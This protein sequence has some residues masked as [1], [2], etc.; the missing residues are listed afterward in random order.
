MVKDQDS[1]E[2]PPPRPPLAVSC[3]IIAKNEEARIAR[4]IRSVTGLVDEVVVVDSGSTDRTIAICRELGAVVHLNDWAGY[5]PQKRFAELQCRN[6]W[7]LNLDAD[8]VLSEALADE[9]RTVMTGG[10]MR[11]D[12]Y[13]LV[14]VEMF[15]G[16][17]RPVPL[18]RRY[19]LIRLYDRRKMRFADS[20]VHDR[21]VAGTARIESMKHVMFHHSFLTLGATISKLNHYT[22][23]QAATNNRHP[24][25]VLYIRLFTEFPL[26]F[27]R[28]YLFRGYFMAGLT[29]FSYAM[30]NAAFRIFRIA[31]MIEVRKQGR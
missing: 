28:Y 4:A 3:F 1:G 13:R 12:G 27:I 5:G 7:L 10:E 17:T 6:D 19:R 11:A 23:L 31:K 26:G 22:D 14:L 15:P 25:W 8:E 2:K 20:A 9:I 24:L 30:V 21:V 18:V 16:R 29:G